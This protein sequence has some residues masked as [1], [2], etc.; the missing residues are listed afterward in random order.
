M[1]TYSQC[2]IARHVS[3]YFIYTHIL[4][5]NIF[6][7]LNKSLKV[8]LIR[9]FLGGPDIKE[10]NAWNSQDYLKFFFIEVLVVARLESCCFMH[11]NDSIILDKRLGIKFLW[12]RV[13][14]TILKHSPLIIE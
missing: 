2:F 5:S 10:G 8:C 11:S 7:Y 12:H 14:W 13:E 6:T 9:K 3:T 4:T 1:H